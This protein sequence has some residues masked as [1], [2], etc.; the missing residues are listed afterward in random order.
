MA[1]II[2]G[3]IAA[4][5][6]GMCFFMILA[7]GMSDAPDPDRGSSVFWVFGIG[8]GL[9]AIVASSHWWHISW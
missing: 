9:A 5:T 6:L 7:N 3:I 2:A 1:F 4:L 8:M